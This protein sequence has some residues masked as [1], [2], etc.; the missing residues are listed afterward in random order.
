[1]GVVEVA[2]DVLPKKRNFFH[3]IG[4]QLLHLSQDC[5]HWPASFTPYTCVR[6]R[7]YA[8]VCFHHCQ[9]FASR[10]SQPAM[11]THTNTHT[12]TYTHIHTRTSC[13]G[14]NAVAAHVVTAA[15][16]GHKRGW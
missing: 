5:F 4:T 10:P 7:V 16:D 1:M 8:Y 14:N 2:V 13:E 6:A 9:C 11:Q 12:H 3:T 15:L